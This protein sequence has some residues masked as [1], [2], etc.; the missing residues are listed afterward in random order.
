W[1]LTPNSTAR[2]VCSSWKPGGFGLGGL[3]GRGRGAG[4][5]NRLRQL[6]TV[7]WLTPR[8]PI[9]AS[10]GSVRTARTTAAGITVPPPPLPLIGWPVG[11]A[12]GPA[13]H[14]LTTHRRLR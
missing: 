7:P 12:S 4:A 10:Y 11:H 8:A 9:N 13:V 14:P 5:P 6:N 1:G 3:G 2:R